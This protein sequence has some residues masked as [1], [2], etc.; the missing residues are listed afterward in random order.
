V[1]KSIASELGEHEEEP[2][3]LLG[4]IV[5]RLGTEQALAFLCETVAI[6]EAGGMLLA[7]GSR[8]RTKGGVFFYLVR[9]K[10]PKPVRRL[11]FTHKA[12]QAS[13]GATAQASSAPTPP[14]PAPF[15]WADRVAALDAI[16]TE[17]GVASTVKITVIGRPG[18]VIDRGTCIVTSMRAKTVPSL[19]K[20]LPTPP[21]VPTNYLVY[22][23]AKQWRKV[24]EAIADPEDVLI[25]EGFPQLDP[26]TSSI[27]VFATNTTTKKLQGAQRQAQVSGKS[28]ALSPRLSHQQMES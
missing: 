13:Q 14:T 28:E 18:K 2:L 20:G 10:G 1:V 17:K 27:A 25:V 21:S 3:H 4:R 6:E 11:F 8:R 9:T 24:A 19:P 12:T 23:A 22:I 5:K 15:T 7:D 16:G 26:E